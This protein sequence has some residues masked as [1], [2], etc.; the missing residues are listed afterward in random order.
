MAR[1]RRVIRCRGRVGCVLRLGWHEEFAIGT[2]VGFEG[3]KVVSPV[4][5]S[6]AAIV[7]SWGEVGRSN[8]WILDSYSLGV[9]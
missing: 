1:V 6:C 5:G 8:A 4:R 9:G 2:D 3:K 7:Y